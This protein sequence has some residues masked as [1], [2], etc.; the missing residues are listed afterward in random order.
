MLSIFFVVHVA[1]LRVLMTEFEII[2]IIIIL[3]SMEKHAKSTFT[4]R[5]SQ[6]IFINVIICIGYHMKSIA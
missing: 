5:N 4:L 1:L 2:A 6:D 3:Q